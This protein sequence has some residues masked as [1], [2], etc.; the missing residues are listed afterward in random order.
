MAKTTEYGLD[1]SKSIYC[2]IEENHM[3]PCGT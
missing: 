2:H 1:S 3:I